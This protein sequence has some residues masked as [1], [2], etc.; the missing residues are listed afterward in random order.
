MIAAPA[1]QKGA[2]ETIQELIGRVGGDHEF[3]FTVHRPGQPHVA[4]HHGR[5]AD[6]LQGG[7]GM[8]QPNSQPVNLLWTGGWDSTFRLLQLLLLRGRTVQPCYVI[9]SNRASTGLELRT[10]THLKQRL[11]AQR[12]ETRKLLLPTRFKDLFD[13]QPNPDITAAFGRIHQR[14]FLGSQYDWLARFCEEAGIHD[15]ELCVERGVGPLPVLLETFSTRRG[16]GEDAYYQVDE[17]HAGSDEHTLLRW[18]NFPVFG[19]S[20][21]DMQAIARQEGFEEFLQMTWF[22]HTP[23]AN[24]RPCGVCNPCIYTMKDGLGA[25]FPFTS[26]LR[27]HLRIRARVRDWLRKHPALHARA[28]QLRSRGAN[29]VG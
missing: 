19:L 2:K 14:C 27:Y 15:M 16:A 13:I 9:D 29:L 12:P 10:M 24:S 7:T 17:I 3:G 20:K 6:K 22:C 8:D 26:R 28:K 5:F 18:F 4:Q 23:R 21:P 11:F 25:R 1:S